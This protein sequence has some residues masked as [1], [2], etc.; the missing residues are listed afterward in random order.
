MHANTHTHSRSFYL[1]EFVFQLA[2]AVYSHTSHN[3]RMSTHRVRNKSSRLLQFRRSTVDGQEIKNAYFFL[4]ASPLFFRPIFLGRRCTRSTR[5]TQIWERP[6]DI[7]QIRTERHSIRAR[8]DATDLAYAWE[9]PMNIALAWI[10]M[11]M[12]KVSSAQFSSR[13]ARR[14]CAR[15]HAKQHFLESRNTRDFF[16]CFAFYSLPRRVHCWHN[17]CPLVPLQFTARTVC[18]ATPTQKH[19]LSRST[20]KSGKFHCFTAFRGENRKIKEKERAFSF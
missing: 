8:N 7:S 15:A 19:T 6:N 5:S 18:A 4:F 17:N 1:C 13:W 9:W 16:C 11:T 12:N 3:N 2:F 20:R 10:Y 14:V